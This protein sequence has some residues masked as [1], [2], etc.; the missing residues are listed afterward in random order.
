M[1]A[2]REIY[3]NIGHA[4]ILPMYFFAFIAVA[5]LQARVPWSDLI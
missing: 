1:E 5:A 4:V 3:R 2:T